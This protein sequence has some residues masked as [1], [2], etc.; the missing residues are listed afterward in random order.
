MN[1]KYGAVFLYTLHAAS[2]NIKI[3]HITLV[4][5]SKLRD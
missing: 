1:F 4:H 3:L 5:L 2:L